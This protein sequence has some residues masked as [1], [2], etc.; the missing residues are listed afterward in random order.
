[1]MRDA[2]ALQGME[3]DDEEDGESTKAIEA[4][5]AGQRG[6]LWK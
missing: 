2:V 4:W 6:R 3:R 5:Y 1:M